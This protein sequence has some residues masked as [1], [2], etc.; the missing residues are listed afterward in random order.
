MASKACSLYTVHKNLKA[1]DCVQAATV[2]LAVLH[3]DECVEVRVWLTRELEPVVNSKRV[4][5]EER[6]AHYKQ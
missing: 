3:P 2:E 5:R 6:D 4:E 1:T